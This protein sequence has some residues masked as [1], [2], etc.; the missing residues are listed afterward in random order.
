MNTSELTNKFYDLQ[1]RLSAY[2]HAVDLIYYDGATT[3]PKESAENRAHAL[4]ILC[5]ESYKLS[6]GDEMLT[7]IEDSL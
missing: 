6:T 4:G 7:L 2:R 3:A 5:E 1:S